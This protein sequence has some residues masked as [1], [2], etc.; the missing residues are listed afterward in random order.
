M[1][2]PLL[3]EIPESLTA[4]RLLLHAPRPGDGPF[5]NESVVHSLDH[6]RRWMPWAQTVPSVEESEANCRDA[7]ARFHRREELRYHLWQEGRHVGCVGMHAPD[8]RIPSFEMGYWIDVRHE[9]RGLVTEAMRCLVEMATTRLNAR[10]LAIRC[11]ALNLRSQAVPRRLGFDLEGILRN[12]DLAADGS[13]S[14][15]DT[16]LFALVR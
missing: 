10:R 9:G 13:G 14:L 8:W 15:R 2:D 16:L 4:P 3:I 7:R 5:L 11:D 12:D 6:L 1:I